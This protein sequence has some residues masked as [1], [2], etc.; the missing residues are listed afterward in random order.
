[1]CKISS[2]EK[3]NYFLRPKKQIERKIFIEILQKIQKPLKTDISKYQY[4]GM[5]S[6]Y[7]YDYIL[8]HKFLG[9]SEMISLDD[10]KCENRFKFNIPY[11]EIIKFYNKK[12]TEYLLHNDIRE[13]SIIWFDYDSKFL[14]YHS[15]MKGNHFINLN[16]SILE[17]L[18]I[19]SQKCKHNVF[20]IITLNINMSY[21][22]F[23]LKPFR[24][25]FVN[26]LN[27]NLSGDFLKQENISYENYP[28]II[29]NLIV[30][31][32]K[33]AG[34][35]N[36]VK[37]NKLFSFVY[38]DG[39]PMFTFGGLFSDDKIPDS[40]YKCSDYIFKDEFDIKKIDVP[41]LTYKEKLMLDKSL[42]YFQNS[43]EKL[44]IGNELE[45]KVIEKLGFEIK[46]EELKNYIE[47]YRYYPQYYE[48]I[49]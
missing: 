33:N 37:F 24:E 17:D 10:K 32:I 29:Q 20:Y 2:F 23:E 41:I 12:T 14:R 34:Q 46:Y 43:I 4:I 45:K 48:G 30:N 42:N 7:Y 1:M 3:I 44:Q 9:I 27:T 16:E 11:D 38:Q 49:I 22:I 36:K 28:K 31:I 47:Y 19:V 18:K 6:I 8:F 35:F 26:K 40:V 13:N 25:Y 15:K 39:T 21:R 5:G